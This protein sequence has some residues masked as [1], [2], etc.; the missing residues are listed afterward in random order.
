MV[1]VSSY[2]ATYFSDISVG[3]LK[4]DKSI[5]RVKLNFLD[6]QSFLIYLLVEP[7]HLKLL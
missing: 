2:R 6:E 3:H 7:E 1:D 4:Q 5:F